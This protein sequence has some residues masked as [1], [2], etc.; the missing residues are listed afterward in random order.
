MK[1]Y[2][3]FALIRA[4]ACLQGFAQVA[5]T[6]TGLAR[7]IFTRIPLGAARCRARI[8]PNAIHLAK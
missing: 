4:L 8:V 7:R 1:R 6:V 3:D 2:S 5:F